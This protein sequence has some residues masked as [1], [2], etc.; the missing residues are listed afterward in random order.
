MKTLLMLLGAAMIYVACAVPVDTH[1]AMRSSPGDHIAP[2]GSG[3]TQQP[4]SFVDAMTDPVPVADAQ[5]LPVPLDI[6]NEACV[7]VVTPINDAGAVSTIW[8]AEHLYPGKKMLE[9]SA[10]RAIA[11]WPTGSF[12]APGYD[13]TVTLPMVRDGAVAVS[14]G[15]ESKTPQ[16]DRVTFILP[17]VQ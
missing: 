15:Y 16:Y 11:H 1:P 9:L 10:V 5:S 13:S 4:P 2:S 7:K 12:F 3:G 14:C 8:Y 17:A 6:A